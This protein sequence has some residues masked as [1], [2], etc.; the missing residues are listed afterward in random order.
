MRA[1]AHPLH[2]PIATGAVYVAALV[3][4]FAA[5][6][7]LPLALAPDLDYPGVAI[8][9][10]WPNATPE[11][12]EAR[13]TAVIESEVHRLDGVRD[14]ASVSARGWGQ[15]YVELERDARVDRAEVFLRDRLAALRGDLPRELA[16]PR[17][18][19]VVPDEMERGSFMTLQA[20][21][22]LS[23]QALREIL[24][25]TV[26]PRL[27]GLRGVAG[28]EIYGGRR[29]EVRI[30][31]DPDALERG[32]VALPDVTRGLDRVGR[33][34]NLG[35]TRRGVHRIPVVLAQPDAVAAALQPQIVGGAAD[36]PVRLSSVAQVRDTWA[37]PRRLSRINGKPAVAVVL[38][39]EPGT[40]VLDV[41]RRVRETL[42]AV[43]SQLPADVRVEVLHDQ[44]ASIRDELS[45]LARRAGASLLAI[46]LVLVLAQR[47]LRAPLVVLTSVLFSAV[48]TFILF[49]AA[50]LGI[51]LVTLSGLALAFGM[52]VDNSIV[53]FENVALR[54]RPDQS[55]RRGARDLLRT[56]AATREVLFPLLAA[57]VTTAVVMTPFLY[58]TGELKDYYL[59]F[60]LSVCF[61]L[62]ASLL[63]AVTLTPLLARWSFGGR[64]LPQLDALAGRLPWLGG[65]SVARV[66][67]AVLRPLLRRP[68]LPAVLAAASLAGAIW[69]FET[70]ISRGSIFPPAD[71]T[72]LRVGLALPDGA[73]IAQT[74]ALIREFEAIVLDGGFVENGFVKRVETGVN[75]NRAFMNVRIEPAVAMT[76]VPQ[77]LKEDLTMRA[78]AISGADV[79]VSGYGPGFSAGSVSSTPSYQLTLR[80]PDYLEL[81]TLAEQ[82]ARRLERHPRIRDVDANASSWMVDDA[83]D[84]AVIP[85][86]ERMARLGVSMREL[87]DTLQPAIAGDLSQRTLRG[88]EGD[89]LGT[90]QIA[91][92]DAF[93]APQV[94]ASLA[95]N[96]ARVAYPLGHLLRIEERPVQ[97]E[98]RRSQQ[99]YER[100]VTFDFRAPRRVGNRFVRSFLENTKLPPG[101]S[102]EDGIGIVLTA[103][104]EQQIALALVLSL[105][106]IYMASAA[107]FEDLLLPFVALLSVPL[108]FVGIVAVFWM[109]DQ[110]FDRTAYVGLILLAGIAIN[111]ALL[112][113]HRAGQLLRR[114]G[115]RV[116][117]VRRAARE[118][119]RPILMTTATSVAGLLPLVVGTDTGASGSWSTLALSATGG[120]VASAC[121][122]LLL[123]PALFVLL[124]RSRAVVPARTPH[125]V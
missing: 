117:A 3:L 12:M 62:A 118:R 49:R 42:D 14:V 116:A 28:A 70:Q 85:D 108:S 19:P 61:S 7:A 67:E 113:V 63:V 106:L 21:G 15:V 90:V 79:S 29:D 73:D 48:A 105:A 96:A 36:H 41:A 52:A 13:V 65:W 75:D 11:E 47:R 112:L 92:A 114:C 89:V 88:P 38:E 37:A 69:V 8:T 24:E 81:A 66:Y 55:A 17:I 1:L 23:D 2:R 27:V 111:N 51:N 43:G 59:P 83:V 76:T 107:L 9:L 100:G 91:G 16:S 32:L 20:S 115:D 30:A 87:V 93:T 68:W 5:M 109:R 74:D 56:L 71:D 46:F 97:G 94:Q 34:T 78:T 95:R 102:V 18:D 10:V 119:M 80:G 50:G 58:L 123:I 25:D 103:R 99:Q 31:L 60:V 6:H 124:A 33:N 122:T 77:I 26:L 120:L 40:N 64:S 125:G 104:E 39:R 57:T 53:I 110:P 4:G 72:G 35:A 44:S 121:V 22:P 101:Y 98:I 84:L 82:I 45:A 86:R 54:R